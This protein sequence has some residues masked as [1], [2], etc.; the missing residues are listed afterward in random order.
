MGM[1]FSCCLGDDHRKYKRTRVFSTESLIETET[2]SKSISCWLGL[3]K[4]TNRNR[5]EVMEME[6]P[7]VIETQAEA[8][9]VTQLA[10]SNENINPAKLVFWNNHLYWLKDAEDWRSKSQ[11]NSHGE[12]SQMEVTV[13]LLR[14]DSSIADSN[15]ITESQKWEKLP[16]E[17]GTPGSSLDL[18]WENEAGLTPPPHYLIPTTDDLTWYVLSEN[19]SNH[20]QP[21]TPVSN[22]N[23]LEWDFTSV[24][25]TENNK[26]QVISDSIENENIER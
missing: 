16:A 20:S 13:P 25:V 15:S 9:R 26:E 3:K 2:Q 24:Q 21:S 1:C 6:R 7:A 10:Q 4:A 17:N 11:F 18:E 23:D 22:G 5:W 12:I 19:S 8:M 14:C